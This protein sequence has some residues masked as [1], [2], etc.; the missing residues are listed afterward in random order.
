MI[1]VVDIILVIIFCIVLMAAAVMDYKYKEVYAF[2][3][4]IEGGISIINAYTYIFIKQ[5]IDGI[6]QLLKVL[7]GVTFFIIVQFILFRR[8]YGIADVKAFCCCALMIFSWG[9]D[10][11]V[12]LLHMGV[13]FLLLAV[14]QGLKGN[15]NRLG[16]LKKPVAFIPYISCAFF[17]SLIILM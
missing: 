2:I 5:D 3:W 12:M 8:L 11:L 1:K 7:S 14:V 9:G 4:W 6:T 10:L 16:N 13:A 17:L 15:I